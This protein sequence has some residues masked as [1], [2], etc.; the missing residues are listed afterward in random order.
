MVEVN[1]RA[2]GIIVL[3]Q[4]CK[5][6]DVKYEADNTRNGGH[7]TIVVAGD[8]SACTAAV[9]SIRQNPPCDV[10]SS[11]VITGPSGEFVKIMEEWKAGRK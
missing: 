10:I 4:M 11:W 3:D 1:G 9:E 8:I 6:A 7:D 5:A 2:N